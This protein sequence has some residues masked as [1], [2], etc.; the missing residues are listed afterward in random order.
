MDPIL[1]MMA[2]AVIMLTL[3]AVWLVGL[4]VIAALERR[5]KPRS[6]PT[7]FDAQET[8][9]PPANAASHPFPIKEAA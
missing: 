8:C 3:I 7:R 5:R 6:T 2:R 1:S 9:V 4:G